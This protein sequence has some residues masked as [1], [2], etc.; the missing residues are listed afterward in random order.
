MS[1]PQHIPFTSILFDSA[2]QVRAEIDS[3]T[4]ADYAEHM[5]DGDKFPPADVFNAESGYH[6]GDGWHRLLAAQKNG[7]V[8]FPCTVHPGGR[9]AAIKFALGANAKHGLKRTNADKRKAVTVALAEFPNLSDRQIAELC[10][11]GHPFVGHVRSQL[12]SDSSSTEPRLGA[13]GKIRRVPIMRHEPRGEVEEKEPVKEA[14]PVGGKLED[15]EQTARETKRAPRVNFSD[16]AE[17]WEIA[18]GQL[19][20][21]RKEDPERAEVLEQ[22]I[23]YAQ[24]RIS[25]NR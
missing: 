24:Q 13:D 8:T 1:A 15:I 6:I 20:N 5:A 12:E 19:D 14:P 16:A 7:D 25:Q 11:V 9:S 2:T 3:A 18:R 4:V 10:G 22:V 21:I 17:R 23:S